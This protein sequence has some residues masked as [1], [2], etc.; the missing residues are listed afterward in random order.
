MFASFAFGFLCGI[1]FS[2]FTMLVVAV[3]VE[4]EKEKNDEV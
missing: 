1:L 4:K 2:V 3:K